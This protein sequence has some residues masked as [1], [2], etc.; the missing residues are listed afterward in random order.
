MLSWYSWNWPFTNLRTKLDFPTADSPEIFTIKK[1][2]I[3]NKCKEDTV[4]A[5]TYAVA[6]RKP[7]LCKTGATL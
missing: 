5:K 6:K 3:A 7:D 2:T 1:K 4:L